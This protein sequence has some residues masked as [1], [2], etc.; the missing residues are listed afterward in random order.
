MEAGVESRWG[1]WLA[2]AVVLAIRIPF[3]NQAIQGD[4]DIYITEAAHAQVDPLHPANTHYVFR[5]DDVDLRGHSHPPLNAWPLALLVGAFGGVLEI[6]FH[7]AYVVFSAIA[8]WAMWSL[9]R[10]FSPHPLW[11]TL[12]FCAVPA[13]VVN[14]NS[15]EPDVPFLAFWMASIALFCSG[16]AWLAAGAMALASL[17]AYQAVFLIPVLGAYWWLGRARRLA[18]E[19]AWPTVLILTPLIVIGAVQVFERLSTGAVPAVVLS[20]YFAHYGFQDLENKLRNAVALTIHFCFIVFPALLPGA[21]VLAWRW[22]RDRDTQFLLAWIAIFFAGAVVVFFAG[23]ARYLL[24]I[25]APVALL[26]SRMRSRWLA[27]GFAAQMALSLGLAAMN[28]QH[29][30]GYRRFAASLPAKT[31]GHRVWVDGDWGYRYYLTAQGGLPLV[32]T[33][34][35]RPGDIVVS[36]ELNHSSDVS[37]VGGGGQATTIAQAEIGSAI[38]LRIIGLGSHSGFSSSSAGLW[39]FGIS[40]GPID[41]IRAAEIGERHVTLEYLPMKAPEADEQIVSGIY[42]DRWMG[43]SG[44]V[45]LKSPPGPRKLRVVFY[46]QNAS[47]P[48]T[49]RLLL[50]GREVASGV[51]SEPGPYTLESQ[52]VQ[53]AGATATVEID[54]DR[55][56]FAPGDARALGIVLT[57]VG[58]AP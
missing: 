44:V 40:D 14:G 24:P 12:L 36:S 30:D 46:V 51:Y 2:L 10:R 54:V 42:A 22:R 31:A 34:T 19:S 45:A 53:A 41:R 39:P 29:W 3:L 57:E 52:A 32:K 35:L 27:L 7:A 47:P 50:D 37:F 1:L 23:S 48:R 49:V 4:D 15:L 16:R 13:F 25:A 21:A 56:F 17:E 55:T 5:G 9:A 8:V 58:F 28:Y 26:V 11:A 20:G 33:Q 18:G 38:P 43:K 6:P